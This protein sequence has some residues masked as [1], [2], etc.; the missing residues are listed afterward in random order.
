[1]KIEIE[2]SEAEQ[3]VCFRFCLLRTYKAAIE[4][5]EDLLPNEPVRNDV[6]VILDDL[7]DTSHH[8][9]SIRSKIVNAMREVQY[10]KQSEKAKIS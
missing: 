9:E 4:V 5:I 10:A 6:Q 8:V 7:E 1:M 2:L 3:L